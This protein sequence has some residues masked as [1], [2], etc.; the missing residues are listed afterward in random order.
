MD[1]SSPRWEMLTRPFAD[2][3][4][5]LLPKYTGRKEPGGKIP[6]EAYRQC[7]ECGGRHPFPCVHLPYVGHANI[8]MRLNEVDPAWNWEPVATDGDGLPLIKNGSLWIRLTVLGVTRLGVGDAN[9]KTGTDATKEIVGDAI[10]NA[11][12]RFGAGTYLWS[13][14]ERAKH[15]S[16]ADDAK[17]EPAPPPD[18]LA[19][20]RDS[21][22]EAKKA[23]VHVNDAMEAVVKALGGKRDEQDQYTPGDVAVACHVVLSMKE[24]A[25]EVGSK[26]EGERQT[27]LANEVGAQ[28]GGAASE[29]PGEAS[30]VVIDFG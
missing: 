16:E 19:P 6:R 22:I 7:G 18:R 26:I 11:A 5:E 15:M 29:P 24:A 1:R 14:S 2:D 12:M 8:T 30:E 20:Y 23:G 3:E 10:R 27:G 25:L 13:K 4:I 17:E 28:D 9:G 21:L